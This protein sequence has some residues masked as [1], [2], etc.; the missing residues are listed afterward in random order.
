MPIPEERLYNPVR[1][2]RWFAVSSILMTASIFWMVWVDYDRPWRA[3]QNEYYLG[4]AALAHLD[5]L[6]ASRQERVNE[7]A[8]A[9]RRLAD[10]RQ[11][12][13]ETSGTKRKKLV[14]DV[15]DADLA[16]RKANAPWSRASQVL[17]VT[18][19][20]YE[21]SLGA[22]GPTSVV[23]Q[24]AYKRFHEEEEEVDRLRKDKE[25]WEDAKKRLE[26]ELKALDEP[27]RTAEKRLG[28]LKQVAAAA[29]QKDQQFRGVLTDSGLLGGLPI[30]KA[31][32]NMPMLDFTAPKNT[33]G[34]HQVNQLV[35]PDV[36]QRLNYLESYTTDRCTTCHVA[37]D[38]PEF[39][40]DRLARKLERS[41]PGVSEAMQ[42]MG[43]PAVSPPSPPAVE[44]KGT[45]LPEGR[46]TE[47]WAELNKK[48]QD[49]YFG[50]LLKLVNDYF[51]LSGRKTI[52]LGQPILA[53]PDLDLYLSVDSAHPMAKIGCTVCHEG[54]PQET[55]F[56]QAAHSPPTHEIEKEWEARYYITLWGIPNITFET[57]AHFWDRPMHLPQYTESGCAK[58]HSQVAD[59]ARFR[60][61]RKGSRINLGQHLF[62]E[63]GCV[64]CHN[65]DALAGSRK[66]GPDLTSVASKL[67]PAFVQ[68]WA[69]FPQ[70]FRPSTRMPHFLL[71]ENNRAESAN[72]FDP[73]PVLRTQTEVASISK[74][75]FSVSKP[76]KPL[77]RP[78]DAAGDAKCGE[79]LFKSLGCLACHAN[80]AEFGEEWITKDLVHREGLNTETALYRY[81]RMTE[82]QRVRYAEEH[83]ADQTHTIFEPE[84]AR[85]DPERPY[86][87]PT[88]SRFAPELSGIGSKV[89]FDWL[90]SWLIEPT[91]YAPDTKMPSLRLSPAEA[92]D[93]ATYLLTL[94]KEEFVQKEF[95]TDGTAR[96]MADDLMFNLLAAQRSERR[97]RAIM[98]DEGSEL[99]NTLVSLLR[100]SLGEQAAY[101]LIRPMS[102]DDKRL[103]YLGNK[104]IG[105][106]GCYACHKI[107]GFEETPPPGTDLSNWAEKPV[108]QLD[109]AF[110]DDAFRDMRK[111]KDQ[112]FGTVYPK[113]AKE[114][115]YWSPT[116]DDL[117][118]QITHTHAAFAKHKVMNPRIWDREKIKRPYDKLKM[119]NFYFTE[120]EAEALTTYLLSRI[121]PRVTDRL[122]VNYEGDTLGPIA[123]G[124]S[125]TRELNC[126]GCHQ[127]E[128][129]APTVQQYFR[130]TMSGRVVFDEINAPPL[131]WGEG[132]KVQHKWLHQFLKQVEPLRPWLLV[133]MPS[134]KLSGEQATT[135]VEYFAALSQRDAKVLGKTLA[136]IEEYTE[137]AR[138]AAKAAGKEAPEAGGDWYQKDQFQAAAT[139]LR[140]WAIER[141]LMRA[142]ELDLLASPPDKLT[143]SH[144]KMLERVEF[145]KKLYTVEYPFVEPPAPLASEERFELGSRFFN[146]MGCLKCH[147][148]GRMLPGPA[149]T[150]DDFVQGYRL[151]GVGGEGD[152]AVAMLNGTP[153]PVGSAIDGFKLTS[154][155][156]TYYDTGDVETKAVIEGPDAKGETERVLLVAASAPNLILTHQRLRREWVYNWML[157]PAWITPG[158][159]MP[160]NFP[161]GKSPFEGDAKYPGKGKDHIE[162]LVDFLFDAGARSTRVPLPKV[163]AGAAKEEFEEAK[164]FEE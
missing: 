30:V 16:F 84:K 11:Y 86:N 21:R 76:W 18:K 61:E 123:K 153:Y 129:N 54:N 159:K 57:I 97:S 131:L 154:A 74:Y 96:R 149:K 3:F 115:N 152:Q 43:H 65:V 12:A 90:Y 55:D 72:R 29:L 120:Q 135:L 142:G 103:M 4:R 155:T 46:V 73:D 156:N 63:V 42:R 58:C 110:Y 122:K 60:G 125:L 141:K 137:K 71:Q 91:R 5:Y 64:N 146:D 139:S 161:D 98:N 133:R 95:P 93:I 158:T 112:V 67:T 47:H 130:R 89:N 25:H 52:E 24:A 33:P 83:F 48:Q 140:Q 106:Y 81:K 80:L 82:E 78:D 49:A 160:Q 109:F 9:E 41:L 145:L 147:V 22:N 127:I 19:D 88:F 136:P 50:E 1:L 92:A 105:H 157:D 56:V 59:I 62:R 100:G 39:S 70:K 114:L 17:E 138:A 116:P 68:P 27:V 134:F 164:E 7:I 108:T 51:K 143:A 13:A 45:A 151:D 118:E 8:D 107:P 75:L 119:P 99:T 44:G 40:K 38:R 102:L 124:R 77:P 94:K 14:A 104:M 34:R 26:T 113:D 35:L 163:P 111:E 148:M 37:I 128:D 121:P 117:R 126:I 69:F 144:A 87:V 66:V 101:D 36:R 150:T 23:T 162:L 79:G 31:I 20:T 2:N 28:D 53:H 15:A 10:A 132:A 6:D 32:I 85:F